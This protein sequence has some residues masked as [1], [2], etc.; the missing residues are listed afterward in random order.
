MNKAIS[1]VQTAELPYA[2]RDPSID[3]TEIH[4]GDIMA[5]GD[6]GI[7]AVNREVIDAALDAVSQ[8]VKDDTELISIYFGHDY[9]EENANRMAKQIQEKYPEIDVA[10]ENGGQPVYYCI[11][12]VE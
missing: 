12:S 3:G 10:V 8:M 1:R 2:I 9:S 5:V 11:I 4:Q 6:H 7:L